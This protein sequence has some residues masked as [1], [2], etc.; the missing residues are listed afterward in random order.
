MKMMFLKLAGMV[1]LGL[2][3]SRSGGVAAEVVVENLPEGGVQPQLAV[4]ADGVVHLVY[5]KPKVKD[6]P[7]NCDVRYTSRPVSGGDWQKPINVNSVP[8]SAIAAGTIRGAQMALGKGGSVQIIWNGMPANPAPKGK[9]GGDQ[10]APLLYARLDPGAPSFTRQ[11]DLLGDTTALDGGASIAASTTGA[12]YVVW[13]ALPKGKDGE[14]QRVVYARRSRDDGH[15]LSDATSLTGD[16][17]GVCPCCSLRAYVGEDGSL[18]VLYRAAVTPLDRGMTWL[19]LAPD[20]GPPQVQPVQGWQTA[21][22]PMSSASMVRGSRLGD[23]RGAWETD[24]RVHT[25]ILGSD[26]STWLPAGPKETAH[27]WMANN[28]QGETLIAMVQGGGWA[29]A[30]NL[31]WRTFD[32]QGK[33]ADAATGAPLPMWSFPVA[34][35]KQDGGFVILR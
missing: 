6:E 11:Q 19:R 14:A 23:V 7:R 15:T 21:K 9:H 4:G 29:K 8:G 3:L 20:G 18:S 27:P 12:V 17:P 33:P 13:H 25:G 35:A 34:Y 22:C 28:E 30:G 2:G 26:P 32:S 1:M 24:D 5:L 16:H 31:Y 10:K